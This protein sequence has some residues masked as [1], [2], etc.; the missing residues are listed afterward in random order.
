MATTDKS[1]FVHNMP[2]PGEVPLGDLLKI[3]WRRQRTIFCVVVIMTAL[4]VVIGMMREKTY[5]AAALVMIQ[6][7]EN[8]IVDLQQVAQGL[9]ASPRDLE[10]EIKFISSH[11]NLAR[12]VDRLNLEAHPTLIF[13]K[14]ESGASASALSD[15]PPIA[16]G[17]EAGP[18]PADGQDINAFR[19]SAI[20]ALAGGLQVVQSGEFEHS[21]DQLHD[22]GCRPSGAARRRNCESLRRQPARPEA[23]GDRTGKELALR[24]GREPPSAGD[25][26]GTD[27]R[28]VPG[29]ERSSALMQS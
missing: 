7:Q 18:K 14:Q 23:G 27:D 8:R 11:E 4:A 10:T 25:E 3:L 21:H 26:F 5:T 12:A 17:A 28:A 20:A 1:N 9:S 24:P 19:E 15:D 22:D 16:G 6:P 2:P 13:P 29:G